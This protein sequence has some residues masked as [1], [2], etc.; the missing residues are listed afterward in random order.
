[1]RFLQR[2]STQQKDTRTHTTTRFSNTAYFKVVYELLATLKKTA[3]T[4]KTD[5]T[6][7]QRKKKAIGLLNDLCLHLDAIAQAANSKTATKTER[8]TE[9]GTEETQRKTQ[10]EAETEAKK[11]ARAEAGTEA[12]LV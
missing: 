10:T 4:D 11:R 5:K 2:N 9:M 7:E 6:D 8:E 12:A 1:M 3:K